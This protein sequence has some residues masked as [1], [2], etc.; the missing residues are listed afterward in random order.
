MAETSQVAA[1]LNGKNITLSDI[2][3]ELD[4]PELK[5][6]LESS[7]NDPAVKT[8]LRANALKSLI[9]RT[10]ML[11]AAAAEQVISEEKVAEQVKTFVES[12]GGKE[13]LEKVIIQNGG[14]FQRFEDEMKESIKLSTFIEKSISKKIATDEKELKAIYEKTPAHYAIPE[15]I[16]A[17]HILIATGNG[18]SDSDA[19]K[20]AQ[21][22]SIKAEKGEDFSKLASEYSDDPGSKAQGGDLG[23]FPKGVMVPEF[24]KIAF[25]LN[26][27]ET[28]QPFKTQFGYHIIKVE[29]KKAG[30]ALS[31]DEAKGKIKSEI[32]AKKRNEQVNKKLAELKAAA[33]IEYMMGEFNLS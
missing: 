22:I 24:E 17:R 20:K 29:G 8:Q 16:H 18:V 15:Q 23:F 1:I 9:E 6:I 31:F 4:R 32:S 33:K 27:G 28:S 14:T 2:D 10:L 13:K 19:L 30:R 12:H 26:P 5:A 21:E 7:Q 3:H 11:E 25:G